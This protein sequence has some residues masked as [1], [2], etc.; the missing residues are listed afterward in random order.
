MNL[1]ELDV[2]VRVLKLFIVLV[3]KFDYDLWKLVSDYYC[4]EE[5]MEIRYYCLIYL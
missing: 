4:Y 5:L 3:I 2:Y 1:Y